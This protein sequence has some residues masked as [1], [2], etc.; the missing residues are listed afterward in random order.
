MVYWNR[1]PDGVRRLAHLAGGDLH[2]LPPQRPEHVLGG[3]LHAR[4][5]VGVDP[6]AHRVR[7]DAADEH[8][9]NAVHAAQF[10]AELQSCVIREEQ[11]VLERLPAVV[12]GKGFPSN[13]A[14]AVPTIATSDSGIAPPFA[15]WKDNRCNLVMT[16]GPSTIGCVLPFLGG[17]S[18]E[19]S[20]GGGSGKPPLGTVSR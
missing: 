20:A 14:V 10:V 17:G 9:A 16:A 15:F 18:G 13:T 11:P 12:D 1:C 5:F 2:V 4:E 19:P 3:E 6:D 7:A 8:V